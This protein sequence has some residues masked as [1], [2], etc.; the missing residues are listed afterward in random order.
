MKQTYLFVFILAI[1]INFSNAQ[2]RFYINSQD[3]LSFK[4]IVDE[5][6][7]KYNKY[8]FEVISN[9]IVKA[10]TLFENKTNKYPQLKINFN[11]NPLLVQKYKSGPSRLIILSSDRNTEIL[12]IPIIYSVKILNSL[13]LYLEENLIAD[14]IIHDAG[15]PKI[16]NGKVSFLNNGYLLSASNNLI[17]TVSKVP[18]NDIVLKSV[19]DI[20]EEEEAALNKVNYSYEKVKVLYRGFLNNRLEILNFNVN[21]KGEVHYLYRLTYIKV[22]VTKLDTSFNISSKHFIIKVNTDK[23]IF[24]RWYINTSSLDSIDYSIDYLAGFYLSNNYVYF[25]TFPYKFTKNKTYN[26]IGFGQIEK[27]EIIVNCLDSNAIFPKVY[28]QYLYQF[29]SA[30]F[31]KNSIYFNCDPIV[32][33]VEDRKLERIAFNDSI[34]DGFNKSTYADFFADSELIHKSIYIHHFQEFFP[35]HKLITFHFNKKDYLA[36]VKNNKVVKVK[37]INNIDERK[38][39]GILIDLNQGKLYSFNLNLK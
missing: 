20:V 30:Y 31:N 13:K 17:D 32:Y 10:Q 34:T 1:S 15:R 35:N 28:E 4:I 21:D 12:N 36:I 14:S 23:T 9:D 3:C 29:S 11:N 18:E 24:K 22:N 39:A 6:I 8:S 37:T 26:F 16:L 5:I 38:N 25:L 19:N 27:E 33:N 2:I 7:R